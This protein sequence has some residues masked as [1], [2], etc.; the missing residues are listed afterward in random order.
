M[1]LLGNGMVLGLLNYR[2][3]EGW[4]NLSV[5]FHFDCRERGA[6]VSY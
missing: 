3:L 4:G 2:D 5:V 1:A 6:E